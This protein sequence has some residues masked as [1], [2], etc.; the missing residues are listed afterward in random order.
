MKRSQDDLNRLDHIAQAIYDKKGST[1]I[2]LDVRD[3]SSL[4]EYF[5][6]AEGNVERHV[7]AIAKS[8]IEN[9]KSEGHIAYH[10]EGLQEGS[11]IVIDFGHIVVHIFEPDL[12][13]KYSLEKL[14]KEGKIVDLKLSISAIEDT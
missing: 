9:Q 3:V 13:E 10:V 11:W 5:V 6:I 12:R 2:A 8:V 4:T 14:W 1:I 7:A